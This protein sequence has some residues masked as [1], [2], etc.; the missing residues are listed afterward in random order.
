MRRGSGWGAGAALH[1]ARQLRQTHR[2]RLALARVGRLVLELLELLLA[3]GLKGVVKLSCHVLA[4][5]PHARD[6]ARGRAALRSSATAATTISTTLG[7]IRQ[8]S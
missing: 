5:L 7:S 2:Q 3:G 6:D 1:T 4:L 8:I